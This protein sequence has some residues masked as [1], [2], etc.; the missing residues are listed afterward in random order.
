MKHAEADIHW[1]LSV[2]EQ[3]CVYC[4]SRFRVVASSPEGEVHHASYE[5][6]ECGKRYELEAEGGPEVILL[7]PRRDGKKD[8]YQ[9]T[10]F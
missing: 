3:S 10:M 4:G 7:Q 8:R 6:P 2:F 1:N 5:C 9:D